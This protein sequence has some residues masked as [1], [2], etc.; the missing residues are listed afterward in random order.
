[1]NAAADEQV[2]EHLAGARVL[3]HLVDAQLVG[4]GAIFQEEVVQQV[5]DQVAAGEDVIAGPGVAHRV[6]AHGPEAGGD[7]VVAVAGALLA[8]GQRGAGDAGGVVLV[9]LAVAVQQ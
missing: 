2:A 5:E 8:E 1:M 4:A 7:E 9:H 3:G 6:A